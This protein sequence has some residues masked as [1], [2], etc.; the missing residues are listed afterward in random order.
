M[1]GLRAAISQGDL[2]AIRN[3][4]CRVVDVERARET[5]CD[6]RGGGGARGCGDGGGDAELCRFSLAGRH[7]ETSLIVCKIYRDSFF[8]KLQARARPRR[9]SGVVVRAP[10]ARVLLPLPLSRPAWA[11]GMKDDATRLGGGGGGGVGGGV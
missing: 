5:A 1:D 10:P 11:A 3:A 9:D 8:W 6:A 2:T 7:R 4:F